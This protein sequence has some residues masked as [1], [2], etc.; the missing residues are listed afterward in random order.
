[1]WMVAAAGA[2]AQPSPAT[3]NAAIASPLAAAREPFTFRLRQCGA[4]G[5]AAVVELLRALRNERDTLVLLKADYHAAGVYSEA[6]FAEAVTLASDDGASPEAR[7]LA[8]DIVLRHATPSMRL[9]LESFAALLSGAR[10]GQLAWC[11]AF[12]ASQPGVSDAGRPSDAR[13][14]SAMMLDALAASKSAPVPVKRV[15]ECVRQRLS[16]IPRIV[17]PSLIDVRYSCDNTFIVNAQRSPW[18]TTAEAV[19]T[20]NGPRRR[21]AIHPTAETVITLEEPTDLQLFLN[22]VPALRVEHGRKSCAAA[23]FRRRNQPIPATIDTLD[24][25]AKNRRKPRGGSE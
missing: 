8:L 15:A 23:A 12:T 1:M 9:N 17:D 11:V 4:R 10:A 22:G 24:G 18:G 21:F 25:W 3:C 16:D 6:L 7:I 13:R 2:E 5:E 20:P 19:T 14:R